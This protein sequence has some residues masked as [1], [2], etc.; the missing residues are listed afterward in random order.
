MA[1]GVDFIVMLVEGPEA[2]VE[3]ELDLTEGVV[4]VEDLVKVVMIVLGLAMGEEVEVI[5]VREVGAVVGKA[6]GVGFATD[7]VLTEA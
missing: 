7:E 3:S 5:F 1:V 2:G 6:T 4:K